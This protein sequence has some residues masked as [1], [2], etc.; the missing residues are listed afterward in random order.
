[1]QNH[2]K[3][4]M[5]TKKTINIQNLF[6]LALV[7]KVGSS[8]LGWRFNDPWI[9][10]FG[11]PIAFM[12]AYI[13]IGIKSEKPG[14]SDDKFADSCYY[15]GFIFT[16]T[17][18]I[19]SLFDLPHIGD[20]INDIA[21]RFGA[22]MV[23][24][25]LGLAVRVYLVT[26]KMN[27]NDAVDLAESAL[28]TSHQKFT[29]QLIITVEQMQAFQEKVDSA[30]KETVERINI[31]L[32]QLSK[33]HAEKL[34]NFFTDL[35]ERNQTSFTEALNEVKKAT[36]RLSDSVESYSSG[37][38]NNIA[39][40]EEKVTAFT[41]AVSNRLETTTFP[42]GFLAQ[43]LNT[44]LAEL[45]ESTNS[46]SS[47]IKQVA[48]EVNTSS[49]TL[50]TTLNKIKLKSEASIDSLDAIAK[51]GELQ[52]T[53]L[54]SSQ[55]QLENLEKVS[56][57]LD[58]LDKNLSLVIQGINNGNEST[59]K[60]IGALNYNFEKNNTKSQELS[61]TFSQIANNIDYQSKFNNNLNDKLKLIVEGNSNE[62]TIQN[63]LINK[64]D[65]F[66]SN[67]NKT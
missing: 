36:I 29:E 45:I 56:S 47:S 51:M 17:S 19:F 63:N 54:I 35:S 57:T 53:I 12:L 10:G 42:D 55:G 44:P 61:T 67:H 25:V 6:A 13:I 50:S 37:M 46:I 65:L 21:I 52:K 3:A 22:A 9:L 48:K 38:G 32:E 2:W 31:Q 24:T 20:N 28:I 18:I 66:L 49:S 62:K 26:F 34:T 33:N 64:L 40:I 43:K 15:L 60:L 14:I 30:T 41:N 27:I 5:S 39:S 7:L 1:M 58:G 4:K 8:F 59:I 11:I 23:S 16:I